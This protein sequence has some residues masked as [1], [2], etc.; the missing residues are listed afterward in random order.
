L[1]AYRG[2]GAAGLAHGNRGRK[3]V[4]TLDEEIREQVV[5]LAQTKYE[6]F[7]HQHLAEFLGE[8]EGLVLSLPPWLF[9]RAA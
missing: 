6:G 1:A 5:E 4:H 3:P 2:E 9:T 7:N 8:Q